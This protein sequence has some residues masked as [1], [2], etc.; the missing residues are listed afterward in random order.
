MNSDYTHIKN[1]KITNDFKSN[2]V[3][4]VTLL[5]FFLFFVFKFV[6]YLTL[7]YETKSSTFYLLKAIQ[8]HEWRISQHVIS[9]PKINNIS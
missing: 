7:V 3:K 5:R 6:R 8:N 4:N 2:T 9:N 1:Q